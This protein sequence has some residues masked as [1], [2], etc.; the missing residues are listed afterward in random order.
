MKRAWKTD[1]LKQSRIEN[2]QPKIISSKQEKHT[3]EG[4]ELV[5]KQNNRPLIQNSIWKIA[6]ENPSTGLE[7]MIIALDWE[8]E[9][10]EI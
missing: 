4:E 2:T 9:E 10:E 8:E 5:E 1:I 3:W 6:S 7:D